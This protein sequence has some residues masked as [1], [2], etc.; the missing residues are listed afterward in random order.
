MESVEL[1]HFFSLHN[2]L[3]ASY[4]EKSCPVF[5]PFFQEN[6]IIPYHSIRYSDFAEDTGFEPVGPFSRLVFE[7]STINRSDNPPCSAMQN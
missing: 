2:A 5:V 4:K 1:A 7:T 6:R 3:K